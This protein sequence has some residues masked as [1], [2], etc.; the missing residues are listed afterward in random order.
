MFTICLVVPNQKHV[1]ILAR[2]LGKSVIE[3]PYI[4]EDPDIENAVL[5][6][7]QQQGAKGK[8]IIC[9]LSTKEASG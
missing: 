7:I 4:C 9:N 2:Q 3:W 8:S 1:E 5:K 6:A